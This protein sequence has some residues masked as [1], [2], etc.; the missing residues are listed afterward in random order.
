MRKILQIDCEEAVSTGAFS[1]VREYLQT[2]Y[3]AYDYAGALYAM[4]KEDELFHIVWEDMNIAKAT[5]GREI[6]AEFQYILDSIDPHLVDPMLC[7]KWLSKSSLNNA[8]V[9]LV[10]EESLQIRHD[11]LHYE[12]EWDKIY[13]G[14]L[15]LNELDE[16]YRYELETVREFFDAS[17]DLH[18]M[19]MFANSYDYLLRATKVRE[20]HSLYETKYALYV[21]V[22]KT[23]LISD[24]IE[25][26]IMDSAGKPSL[27]HKLL[28]RQFEQ[29]LQK[30][31][32]GFGYEVNLTA[33]T[34]DGGIDLLCMKNCHDI[35][36][37]VAIEAKHYASSNPISISLVRSFVGAN[38][39]VQA[40]KLVY[41]TTSRYT[42]D[43]LAYSRTPA[44][45]NLLELKELPDIVRWA[46]DF[47]CIRNPQGPHD[48]L[49]TKKLLGI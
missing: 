39:P 5:G 34:R 27:I 25:Q 38:A 42:K 6:S 49:Q 46:N 7:A 13:A 19:E 10:Q 15:D 41:V 30:I 23:L 9:P 48:S 11:I 47:K 31:F 44:L 2:K 22:T 40:N 16:F 26:I 37:C 24:P 3:Y 4:D 43:A 28:P 21:P 29:Y 45:T 1:S 35:P 20:K 33:R 12:K 36:I 18:L 14:K 8:S 17:S 32:E